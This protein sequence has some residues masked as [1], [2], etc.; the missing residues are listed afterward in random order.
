MAFNLSVR[1]TGTGVKRGE[2]LNGNP[3]CIRFTLRC[4]IKRNVKDACFYAVKTKKKETTTEQ[5]VSFTVS[6][7][8]RTIHAFQTTSSETL[9]I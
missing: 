4:L 1:T 3:L 8:K 9:G 2:Q 6:V 7:F 5:Q